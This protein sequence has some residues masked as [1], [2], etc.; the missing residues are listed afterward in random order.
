[1]RSACAK[2]IMLLWAASLMLQTP[3]WS[4]RFIDTSGN[5]TEKYI[6][7][8]SDKGV[9]PASTDG[10]FQPDQPVTRAQLAAWLVKVLGL[11]NQPVPKVSSFADVKPADWY[12]K[13]VEIIR[14]NNYISGYADGF[15]PNQFIQRA[16]VMTILSRTLNM[17]APDAAAVSSELAKYSDGNKVPE[18]AK[19]GVAMASIAGVCVNDKDPSLL[20][21]T[22]IATRGET[23][24]L[25]SKLDEYQVRKAVETALKP[26]QPGSAP[27]SSASEGAA[28]PPNA[29]GTA[30][31]A[32]PPGAYQPPVIPGQ[33][34]KN[35]FGAASP[36]PAQQ[37]PAYTPPQQSYAPA[38]PQYAPAGAYGQPPPSY[39]QGGVAV[40]AAGTR[41]RASLANTLDS[42]MT[43]P[44][45]PVQATIGEPLYV[46]G[47]EVV[48]A[49]SKL[50]GSVT[51]ASAA[52]RFHAG[53]N[54][55]LDIKFTSI[56][57][58]DGRRFPV[59]ASV[60]GG[61]IKMTG[62]TTAGRV[63]K[64]LMTTGIGAG[65]GAVLGTALGAIVGAT[66]GGGHVGK[67]TAMGAIFGTAIGGGAGAIGGVVRKGSE[68]KIAAGTSLP[69]QLDTSL[70]ITAPPP[71]SAYGAPPAYGYAP[72]PPGYG[73]PP[74]YGYAPQGYG[75]PPSYAY[76]PPNPPGYYPQQ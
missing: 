30:Y 46:N 29:A 12:F 13:P 71:T 31:G 22:A 35:A 67:A 53:A 36:P 59:Q 19:T 50:I 69:V 23:V 6:N 28:P 21:P 2:T 40:V 62:G 49:G 9:I 11:E 7:R 41:F 70:T 61:E 68:A 74:A 8:L 25:L 42:G 73:A 4:A 56:E 43:R 5:W 48:P 47:Q 18:W 24:A 32:Y 57:T 39:L 38:A 33:V 60:D 65:S 76:P 52:K 54:G 27:P 75:A 26:P 1:M 51:D 44:G 15:R 58:P 63:G 66:S 14:Q 34:E 37:P 17:P 3:A 20:N 55:K 10:K 64:G 16:E 72:P 45:E